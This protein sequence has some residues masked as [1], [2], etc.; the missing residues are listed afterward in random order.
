LLQSPQELK[1][2]GE[3]AKTIAPTDSA[4]KLAQLVREIVEK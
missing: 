2:M 1:A 3:K 4:E